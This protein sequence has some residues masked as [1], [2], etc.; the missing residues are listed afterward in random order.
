MGAAALNTTGITIIPAD[1]TTAQ[2]ITLARAMESDKNSPTTPPAIVTGDGTQQVLPEDL[3]KIFLQVTQ[4][5]ASGQGVSIVPRHR[6]LSTHE[7]ADLL[8][9]SRLALIEA[10]ENGELPF[11]MHGSHRCIQLE[12]I[13]NFQQMLAENRTKALDEM[14]LHS[15]Q[16]DLYRKLDQ[17]PPTAE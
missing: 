15:Q 17:V 8:N 6:L 9:I 11:E 3:Y 12:D 2:A 5:F 7:A 4:A 10:L 14:Q 1:E 13:L 16:H